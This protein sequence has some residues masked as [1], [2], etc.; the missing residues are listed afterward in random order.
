[1]SKLTITL[2]LLAVLAPIWLMILRSLVRKS[3][4]YELKGGKR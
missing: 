1:M 2:I 3:K 4:E